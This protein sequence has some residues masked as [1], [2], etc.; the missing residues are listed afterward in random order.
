VPEPR[1]SA[2]GFVK[3]SGI[4][5]PEFRRDRFTYDRAT[6]S[7]LC[8]AGHRLEYHHRIE[9]VH[10]RAVGVYKSDACRG[11]PFISSCTRNRYGRELWRWEHEDV[12][13]DLRVKMGSDEG[14]RR[15]RLRKQL[16]EHSFG[17]V[18][19]WHNHGYLLLRG[20]GR[21]SGELGL[22]FLAYNVIRAVNL[23]GVRA[24]VASVAL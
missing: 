15:M 11:C 14:W 13:E 16:C 8:P 6:D 19:R 20:L 7:Y 3:M 10:G 2:R 1:T 24:L 17:T 9:N 23:V 12:V 18:K 4:P 22:E 21:V 5:T